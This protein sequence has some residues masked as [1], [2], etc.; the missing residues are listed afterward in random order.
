MND[1]ANVDPAGSTQSHTLASPSLDAGSLYQWRI[2]AT[3][4][5]GI[6]P[7]AGKKSTADFITNGAQKTLALQVTLQGTGTPAVAPKFNVKLY[8]S[9][10][11]RDPN[12][13]S[14][15]IFAK[16]P[17]ST[18]SG[19]TGTLLSGRTYTVSIPSV[20]TGFYDITIES[21]HTLVNLKDDAR[22]HLAYSSAIDMGTLKEGNAIDDTRE[23]SSII[24]A[25]D[26]SALATELQKSKVT[27]RNP[28]VDFNRDG[29]VTA[30]DLTLLQENYLDFSP[31]TPPITLNS[32][33]GTIGSADP[34]TT[35][36]VDGGLPS[37]VRLRSLPRTLPGLQPSLERSTS[38]A[39]P[40]LP[41]RAPSERRRSVRRLNIGPP[42][43]F[44]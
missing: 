44:P 4:K 42:L 15:A 6:D 39:A 43:A 40:L 1:I 14:W 3:T 7:L 32:G 37:I 31:V 41:H 26:A 36:S 11:S 29:S 33:V 21:D 16:T 19:L 13:P 5:A 24:N 2:N 27:D 35:V 17:I 8:N 9:G 20:T 34:S 25:L 30:A 22:V 28:N 38:A 18:F 23:G 12:D 10:A